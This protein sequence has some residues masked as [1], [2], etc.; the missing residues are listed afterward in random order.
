MDMV[1]AIK[2]LN[3]TVGISSNEAELMLQL[4]QPVILESLLTDYYDVEEIGY[5]SALDGYINIIN[6]PAE[7]PRIEFLL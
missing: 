2:I 5:N 1:K 7:E 4:P 3:A 6:E